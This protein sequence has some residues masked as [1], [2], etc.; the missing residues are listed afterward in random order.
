[1]A[2]F[3]TCNE[4]SCGTNKLLDHGVLLEYQLPLSSRRLDCLLCG[5]NNQEEPNAVVVELKQWDN[6]EHADGKMKC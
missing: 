4:P 3:I 5:R 6:C 1:M 2:E